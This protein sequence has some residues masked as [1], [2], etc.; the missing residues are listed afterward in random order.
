MAQLVE[1]LRRFR[2]PFNVR[3]GG[4]AAE[5]VDR[6]DDLRRLDEADRLSSEWKL[7]PGRNTRI[8]ERLRQVLE[9]SAVRGGDVLEIGA[10]K[11]PRLSLFPEPTWRY[12][13]LDI[14]DCDS[15]VP[16]LI[17]DITSCPELPDE[18]FDVI[19]SVDVFE[20]LNR[21]WLAA[22]EITRLLRPGGV[23]FT[24]TLFAWRYHPVP[25]D[26]WR[27][28]PPCLEF[29]FGDLVTVLSE[30]DVTERRRSLQGRGERDRVPEDALGAFRENWRVNHAA[31]RPFREPG[32]DRTERRR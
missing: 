7:S 14:V 30:F 12:T 21:P 20:H 4:E 3:G 13:V 26:Y 10:R 18:S 16:T 8:E 32:D 11:R 28:T 23:V 9:L 19:V 31:R 5:C 15:G 22:E 25:I 2:L 29:L 17:A 6:R 1:R 24:S 27:F